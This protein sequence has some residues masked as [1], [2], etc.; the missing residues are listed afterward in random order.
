MGKKYSVAELALQAAKGVW[1]LKGLVNSEVHKVDTSSSTTVSSTGT[2]IDLSAVANGDSSNTRT[3]LSIFARYMKLNLHLIVNA[4]ATATAVKCMVIVDSQ[5]A[6]DTAPAVTDVLTSASV[7]SN[8]NNGQ[9]PRFKVLFSK[10]YTLD[11]LGS[12]S[13]QFD[14][15][16]RKFRIHVK[17]NGSATTDI[18]TNGFYLLMV[19]NEATNT[20]T[21]YYNCRFG[22]H[23]N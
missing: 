6:S 2:V 10:V 9:A 15:I 8:L 19:S 13:Q 21:V 20:P 17:Y 3:G 23:D 4:S 1:Y 11:L 14:S 22:F 5:N 16:E 12:G 18:E 7:L